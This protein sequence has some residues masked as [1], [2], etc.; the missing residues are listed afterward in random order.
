MKKP[1][2]QKQESA[3][4]DA[5]WQLAKLIAL[6]A[7]IA[8]VF[9]LLIQ[10]PNIRDWSDSTW[11]PY[12]QDNTKALHRDGATAAYQSGIMVATYFF[13]QVLVAARLTRG[14]QTPLRLG[15][16]AV[17]VVIAGFLANGFGL[18]TLITIIDNSTG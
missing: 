14:F 6:Y 5:Y 9:W 15:V 17:A 10:A 11:Y 12:G 13:V 18:S 3:P 4:V 2:A 7:V 1:S 8:I 16:L